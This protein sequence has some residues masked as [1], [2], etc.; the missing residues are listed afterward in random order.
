MSNDDFAE[1]M[2]AVHT[3]TRRRLS[4]DRAAVV[5]KFGVAGF[6]GYLRTGMYPDGRLGEIFIEV[7][8]EGSTVS[9]L[10]NAFATS[11][12]LALQYGVPLKVMASKFVGMRFEP[13]GVAKGH[14]D[15]EVASSIVDY[16]FRYLLRKYEGGP[17][18]EAG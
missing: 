5:H 6:E 17:L 10:L 1:E 9:G 3:S 13:C 11:I 2:V 18:D 12:S 15:I 14:K 4:N 7:S 16:I 8:K